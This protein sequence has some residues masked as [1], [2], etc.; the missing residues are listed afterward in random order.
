M[1]WLEYFK[2]KEGTGILSTADGEG[3]VDSAIYAR[4]HVNDEGHLAFVM[5]GRLSY[6]NLTSNPWAVYLFKEDVPG[7]VGVRLYLRRIREESNAELI[8]Q[9]RRRPA[10]RDDEAEAKELHLVWFE[11]VKQRPLVD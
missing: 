7:Y 5:T 4:P 9:L 1:D 10:S 8:S 2:A 3:R 6:R 11:L